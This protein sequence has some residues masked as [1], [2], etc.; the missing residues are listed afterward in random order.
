LV[1]EIE[2]GF[3]ARRFVEQRPR[4]GD[5]V[6]LCRRRQLGRGLLALQGLKGHTRVESG[7]MISAFRHS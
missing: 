5:W 6:L 1:G 7:V 2:D 4:I 3:G